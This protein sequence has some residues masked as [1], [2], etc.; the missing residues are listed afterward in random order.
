MALAAAFDERG[1]EIADG[2]ARRQ[3]GRLDTGCLDDER[4]LAIAADQKIRERLGGRM[5]FRADAAATE[6]QILEPHVLEQPASRL[7]EGFDR[8]TM[9]LVIV[10]PLLKRRSRS[11]PDVSVRRSHQVHA[12]AVRM[13]KR[14]DEGVDERSLRRRKLDVFAAARVDGERLS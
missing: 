2:E 12:K 13:R 9:A 10:F 3:P 6:P 4:I 7:E 8:Q 5:D 14:I 1:N 11:K